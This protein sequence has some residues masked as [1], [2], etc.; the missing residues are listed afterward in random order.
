MRIE[1]NIKR[2]AEQACSDIGMPLCSAIKNVWH[3][4]AAP[5]AK[6]AADRIHNL[7]L[8]INTQQTIMPFQNCYERERTRE[9]LPE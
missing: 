8:F 5:K 7:K 1:D 9:I 2:M 6:G 3:G 4:I